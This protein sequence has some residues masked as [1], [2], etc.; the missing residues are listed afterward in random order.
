MLWVSRKYK[1]VT[2]AVRGLTLVCYLIMI[3]SSLKCS[4]CDV[5]PQSTDVD[6]GIDSYV[7]TALYNQPIK[8]IMCQICDNHIHCDLNLANSTNF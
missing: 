2:L 7:S 3:I 8:I 6:S 1:Y 5:N 4:F